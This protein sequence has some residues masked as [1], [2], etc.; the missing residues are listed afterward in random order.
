[1]KTIIVHTPQNEMSK[2]YRYYNHFWGFFIEF[3]KTK[4]IVEEDTYYDLAN[5]NSYGVKLLNDLTKSDMLECEMIIENKETKEFVVLSVSDVLTGSVLNH[6]S[7]PLCKKVLFSQ[8]DRQMIFNHVNNNENRLKYSP[9]IYFPSNSFDIDSLYDYRMSIDTFVDKF[10]FWGTSLECRSILS[11]FD[12]N[13]FDGGRPIGDFYNYSK[14]LLTYKIALS[15][16]GR[17]EFCYRDI[18]NFGMGIPIIRFEFKNELY[19]PLIPNFHYISIDRPKDLIIDREG[20]DY[21]AKLIEERFLEVKDDIDFLNFISN[22]ARKYYDDF[23]SKENSIITT[24]N[25]LDLE[26]WR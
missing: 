25:I 17:G 16:S 20:N 19:N 2:T 26:S 4:F 11:H 8:F 13:Y 6:Q 15:I 14:K 7:N 12:Q 22:N 24:Y 23:L 3:L 10:C 1:V 5:I 9:W 18:E 21:H